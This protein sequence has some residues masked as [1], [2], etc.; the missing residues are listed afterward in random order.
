VPCWQY[1]AVMKQQYFKVAL[2]KITIFHGTFVEGIGF[3]ST[4]R[5]NTNKI[6]TC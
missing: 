3:I 2:I 1:G 4:M 5:L 6:L